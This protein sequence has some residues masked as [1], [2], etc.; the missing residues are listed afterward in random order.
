MLGSAAAH[1]NGQAKALS[2]Y[3]RGAILNRLGRYDQALMSLDQALTEASDLILAQEERGESLWQLG[4]QEEAVAVWKSVISVKAD[5]PLSNNLLAGAAALQGQSAE[6]VAYEKQADKFTPADPL[7]LWIL[8]IRLQNVGMNDLAEK[9][10]Q[11]AIQL[12]PEFRKA[13]N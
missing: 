9:H 12:N 8:G 2:F 11:R 13:R 1:Q 7:F 10:F 6:S 5:L 3:Y 4:R